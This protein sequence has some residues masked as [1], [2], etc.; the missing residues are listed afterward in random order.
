MSNIQLIAKLHHISEWV[1]FKT[2]NDT[3]IKKLQE[4]TIQCNNS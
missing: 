2:C 1:I 3:H 4:S